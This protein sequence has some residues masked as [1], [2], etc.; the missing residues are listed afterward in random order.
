MKSIAVKY[1]Y[2]IIALVAF[3][4]YANTINHE[5]V[6]DDAFLIPENTL[7]N[8]GTESISELFKTNYRYGYWGPKDNLYRPL[9][10]SVFATLWEFS[11]GE[12][13]LF[14][15]AN[16]LLFAGL[17][18][19][20]FHFLW[21]W[22]TNKLFAAAV[23]LVFAVHPIHTEVVA[24]IKSMDEILSLLSGVWAMYFALLFARSKNKK[25]LA[26]MALVAFAGFFTKESSVLF[27]AII[28][29]LLWLL[30][31]DIKTAAFTGGVLALPLVIFLAIRQQVVGGLD[32]QLVS[33]LD[34]FIAH[35]P[36]F[37][38]KVFSAFSIMGT[39]LYKLIVPHPLVYEQ[40]YQQI[41]FSS[42][43]NITAWLAIVAYI[44]IGSFA[45]YTIVKQRFQIV[46][47]GLL[48]FLITFSLYTN[49]AFTIGSCYGERFLFTPSLG[50][51]I[52][53]MGWLFTIKLNDKDEAP[54][55]P[56]KESQVLPIVGLLIAVYTFGT[57]NRNPAWSDDLTLYETDLPKAENSAKAH[58]S[59]GIEV[60]QER[61]MTAKNV[62]EK[63]KYLEE[64]IRSFKRAIDIFPTYSD[65]WSDYALA[66][67]RQNKLKES[68]PLYEKALQFNPGNSIGWNNLGSVYYQLQN[69][70]KAK[71]CFTNAVQYN[72]LYVDALGNLG[73]AHGTLGEHK[74]A[75]I[76]FERALEL[77]PNTASFY[78]YRSI[79]YQ[80][81]GQPELAR[82]NIEKA[83]SLEPN[84]PRYRPASQ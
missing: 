32:D 35:A 66:V 42:A 20:I 2:L 9:T 62:P 69:I 68:I 12:P 44:A 13:K 16:I 3:G 34:N 73:V 80:N 65:A 84:N 37:S 71:E 46:G 24:N 38:T 7:V 78:F 23:A 28:P 61:A 39:Y 54:K 50:I 56:L 22:T 47:F 8:H 1:L 41:S 83:A 19:S 60:M 40:A 77:K 45:I 29:F 26:V 43:S 72:P 36:D 58:Y 11:P 48:F 57:V 53:L 75:L 4:V 82:Q 81:M 51:L 64:S 17:C 33:K 49:L 63:D 31:R 21:K 27:V 25:W 10:L 74:E 52:A 5:F 59:Y 79:S 67:F 18:L 14:H 30:N 6:L 76:Y 15:I 55:L 70:P